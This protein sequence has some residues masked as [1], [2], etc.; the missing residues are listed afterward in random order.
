[1]SSLSA[2]YQGTWKY[3]GVEFIDD[4]IKIEVIT[5]DDENADDFFKKYKERLKT[6]LLQIGI[7]ITAQAIH[8]I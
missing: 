1:M 6:L 3:G 2:P 5:I 7:L 4:I 8:T